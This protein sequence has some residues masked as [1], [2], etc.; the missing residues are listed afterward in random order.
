MPVPSPHL[1]CP[2]VG[3]VHPSSCS[4][5]HG[6]LMPTITTS[7][8]SQGGGCGV[9]MPSLNMK[10]ACRY[11]VIDFKATRLQKFNTVKQ[12]VQIVRQWTF[13]RRAYLLDLTVS[14]SCLLENTHVDD[15]RIPIPGK[16]TLITTHILL[17]FIFESVKSHLGV[18]HVTTYTP[19][20][21]P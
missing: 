19:L 16:P 4:L 18:L 1:E 11:A 6:V 3:D 21:I 9:S 2:G 8:V 15:H 12:S 20:N 5:L 10:A 7:C 14:Q 17:M 13:V